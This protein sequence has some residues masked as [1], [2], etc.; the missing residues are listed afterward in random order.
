MDLF[1]QFV[2]EE[3]KCLEPLNKNFL[4]CNEGS[5]LQNAFEHRTLI[6]VGQILQA[7]W[8]ELDLVLPPNM[9]N[10]KKEILLGAKDNHLAFI[11]QF[12]KHPEL[13]ALMKQS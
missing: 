1:L 10:S 11:A 3:T 6:H 2:R 7:L 4:L 12:D 8:M 9:P 13:K 5:F